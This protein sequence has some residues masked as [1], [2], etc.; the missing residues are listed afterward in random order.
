MDKKVVERIKADLQERK[1]KIEK[2]LAEFAA[3]DTKVEGNFRS[4][5]PDFGNKEDEN[6]EEI[7]AYGDRLSIE[8]SLENTLRDI[9]KALDAIDKGTY[10]ICKYCGNPISE[11]RLLARPVSS[12]CI[13]CK[14][15]LANT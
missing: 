1:A 2:E 9:R 10:G 14:E 11:K 12:S 8:Y 4:E 3:K 5:F 7:A 13:E 15:H 6:A